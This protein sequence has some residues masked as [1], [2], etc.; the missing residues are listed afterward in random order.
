MIAVSTE[1]TETLIIKMGETCSLKT[2]HAFKSL[3]GD[4]WKQKFKILGLDCENLKF[5]D[6][7]GIAGIQRVSGVTLSEKDHVVFFGLPPDLKQL[8]IDNKWD[9]IFKIMEKEKFEEKY[10]SSSNN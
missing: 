4:D 7:M 8:F 3:L 10:C 9:T 2:G 6:I 1:N 5:I